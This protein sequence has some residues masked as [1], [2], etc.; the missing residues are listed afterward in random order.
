PISVRPTLRGGRPDWPPRARSPPAGRRRTTRTGRGSSARRGD[1]RGDRL[2]DLGSR[3]LAP[4]VTREKRALRDLLLERG[5][6]RACRVRVAEVLEHHRA[7]PDLGDRVSDA[8]AG[9]VGGGAVYRLEHRRLLPPR[10]DVAA[11][12]RAERACEGRAGVGA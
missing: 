3:G 6:D 5:H 10:G 9:D 2:A 7:R 12:G 1:P 11:G 8:P 4:E